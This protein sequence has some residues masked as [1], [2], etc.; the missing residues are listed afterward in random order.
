PRTWRTAPVR[1]GVIAQQGVGYAY[2]PVRSD[3]D[4]VVVLHAVGHSAVY[5]NGEPRGGDMYRS[6][7]A[8]L[9]VRLH[10]GANDLLFVGGRGS[11]TVKFEEPRGAAQ[12]DTADTTA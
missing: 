1:D 9:P 11:I 10:D 4:R 5:V 12:L 7:I 8:R 6:G 2:L 3:G